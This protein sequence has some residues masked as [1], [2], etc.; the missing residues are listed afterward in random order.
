VLTR[1]Y[2]RGGCD[3][4]Q[5]FELSVVIGKIKSMS[6][7]QEKE[8]V[9]RNSDHIQTLRPDGRPGEHIPRN[10]Y[11]TWSYFILSTLT[12]FPELTLTALLEKADHHIRASEAKFDSKVSW[13]VLQVKRDL[14]ARGLIKVIPAS[15]K[16]HTHLIQLT[17]QG[18][19][20]INYQ[21]QVSEWSDEE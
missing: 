19:S 7:I 17:R 21:L 15:E 10:E 9:K 14:E 4:N 12:K 11:E 18:M 5:S 1:T 3:L 2:Y 8:N 6:D 16:K 20:K 13:Y